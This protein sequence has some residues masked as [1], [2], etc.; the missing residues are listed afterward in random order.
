MDTLNNQIFATE[1]ST[2]SETD[3]IVSLLGE[4]LEETGVL[5]LVGL[6]QEEESNNIPLKRQ[7]LQGDTNNQLGLITSNDIPIFHRGIEG[8]ESS[9][10]DPGFVNHLQDALQEANDILAPVVA[11]AASAIAAPAAINALESAAI[12]VAAIDG[13]YDAESAA[14]NTINSIDTIRDNNLGHA[15]NR[16]DEVIHG[17][18]KG[19]RPLDGAS[20]QASQG[21]NKPLSSNNAS[22]MPGD[23]ANIL[24]SNST[25]RGFQSDEQPDFLL[26]KRIRLGNNTIVTGGVYGDLICDIPPQAPATGNFFSTYWALVENNEDQIQWDA[27]EGGMVVHSY[28]KPNAAGGGIETPV[29]INARVFCAHNAPFLAN[30]LEPFSFRWGPGDIKGMAAQEQFEQFMHGGVPSERTFVSAVQQ[31][32]N[33]TNI[34]AARFLTRGLLSSPHYKNNMGMYAKLLWWSVCLDFHSVIGVDPVAEAFVAGGD[35]TFVNIANDALDYNTIFDPI[36]RGDIMM[37]HNKDYVAEDLQIVMWLAKSG[38]RLD[39]AAGQMTPHMDRVNWPAI[40][41]TILHHGAA[42]ALPAAQLVTSDQLLA[43]AEKLATARGE[44]DDLQLGLY[45]INQ[46]LGIQR[47]PRVGANNMK[48]ILP[49]MQITDQTLPIPSDYNILHRILKVF[50]PSDPNAREDFQSYTTRT[51]RT[52]LNLCTLYSALLS[53]FTTTTFHSLNITT[54]HLQNWKTA[55]GALPSMVSALF[56]QTAFFRPALTGGGGEAKIFTRPHECFKI[57]AGAS[58]PKGMFK[59]VAYNRGRGGVVHVGDYYQNS[60]AGVA[61]RKFAPWIVDDWIFIRPLE[62]GICG[63]NTSVDL[64]KEIRM[65][66]AA[67]QLGWYSVRGSDVYTQRAVA[68]MPYRLA[69]YG[70]QALNCIVNE[71]RPANQL[72]SRQ[73]L[74]WV[75]RGPAS[76]REPVVYNGPEYNAA[77]HNFVPCTIMSYDYQNQRVWAPCLVGNAQIGVNNRFRL[78]SLTSTVL[79]RVGFALAQLYEADQLNFAIPAMFGNFGM[80]QITEGEATS[81]GNPH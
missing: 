58:I 50:P 76:T 39:G 46:F 71:I 14:R 75:Q 64:H 27:A 61:P 81:G 7:G 16:I 3:N 25:K 38:I 79:Q 11:T 60:P 26:P 63:Q 33:L 42:P 22:Q 56:D 57:F 70:I 69:V 65:Q 37:L 30:D 80:G 72:I 53:S 40:P 17:E 78:A 49:D 48:F 51:P 32:L 74:D 15:L 19:S 62:W 13:L 8:Q 55:G 36:E 44:W 52:R 41:I 68:D 24:L 4:V 23:K 1:A 5:E 18:H 67:A 21:D 73:E 9:Q 47:L 77:V 35:P 28:L 45:Y 10:Q 54:A 2:S 29:D 12:P 66:G 34:S 59:G 6:Q 20:R 31:E 43:F